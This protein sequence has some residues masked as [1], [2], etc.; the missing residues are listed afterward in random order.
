MVDLDLDVVLTREGRLFV[1][2]EDEFAEHQVLLG[3]PAEVIA[4]AEQW[5]DTILAAVAAGEEPFASVEH[6]WLRRAEAAERGAVRGPLIPAHGIRRGTAEHSG[7]RHT[8]WRR[9][10]RAACL[11]LGAR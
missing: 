1:D 8:T 2:D 6:D 9:R 4:L 3:Y 7:R 5:R 11:T 10:A